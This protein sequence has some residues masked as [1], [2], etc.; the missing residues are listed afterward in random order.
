MRCQCRKSQGMRFGVRPAKE[1]SQLDRLVDSVGNRFRRRGS[2]CHRIRYLAVFQ[3]AGVSGRSC[4]I[5][6][7]C[8]WIQ[9]V[10]FPSYRS[11]SLELNDFYRFLL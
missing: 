8:Y 11:T 4:T 1:G 5:G 2:L 7:H 3:D 6:Q 9:Q 10:Y